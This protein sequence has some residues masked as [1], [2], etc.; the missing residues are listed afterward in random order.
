M[1]KTVKEERLRWVLPIVRGE[2]KLG[3]ATR[4]CPYGK[5]SL[6]RWAAAYRRGGEAAL[7]PLSTRPKT[8]PKETPIHV[9][10]AIIA[11]RKR[12]KVCALKLHWKLEK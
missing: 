1:A 2:I 4:V 11:L 10:E 3:D 7:E 9:K 8:S 5:R 6:E 12:K